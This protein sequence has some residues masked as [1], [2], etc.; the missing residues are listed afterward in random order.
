M[1]KAASPYPDNMTILGWSCYTNVI[2]YQIPD[3]GNNEK[4]GLTLYDH[5]IPQSIDKDAHLL[6]YT[7][8]KKTKDELNN[9]KYDADL[10]VLPPVTKLGLN[11]ITGIWYNIGTTNHRTFNQVKSG[12]TVDTTWHVTNGIEPKLE[13][14]H[15]VTLF[16][17]WYEIGYI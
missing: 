10:R 6:E 15:T 4:H 13:N 8:Y 16:F 5:Q 7:T 3:L 17:H 9:W 2:K 11:E 1:N 12:T 14:T